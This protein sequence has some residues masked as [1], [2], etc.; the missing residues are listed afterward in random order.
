METK[1]P[2]TPSLRGELPSLYRIVV[3]HAME[4]FKLHAKLM[5]LVFCIMSSYACL[6]HLPI[7]FSNAES[8][9]LIGPQL[10]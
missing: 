10:H 2:S 6:K 4:C 1:P 8:P 7:V 5:G 9:H 3:F